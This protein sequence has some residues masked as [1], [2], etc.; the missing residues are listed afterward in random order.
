MPRTA[1]TDPATKAQALRIAAEHGAAEASRQTGVQ[2]STI[3]AWKSRE[4]V[5]VPPSEIND[6]ERL[7]RT[8]DQARRVA[9]AAIK[10]IGETLPNSR[11]PRDLSISVGVLLDKAQQLSENL[12]ALEDRDI[13]IS[14]QQTEVLVVVVEMFFESVGLPLGEP[15]LRAA[16]RALLAAL[17]RQAGEGAAMSPPGVETEAARTWVRER[18]AEDLRPTLRAEIER[19]LH[20]QEPDSELADVSDRP[21]VPLAL[22]AAG[23]TEVRELEQLAEPRQALKVFAERQPQP[24]GDSEIVE[25]EVVEPE[26]EWR[27]AWPQVRVVPPEELAR[28]RR[29]SRNRFSP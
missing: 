18:V 29:G 19:E 17:L 25:G 20:D 9:D 26:P 28:Q 7:R 13:R 6:I 4:N 15:T 10:R 21:R 22:P 12:Q 14:Q 23:E 8:A 24:V 27:H 5:A 16:P 11:N 1:P 2:A 3:R